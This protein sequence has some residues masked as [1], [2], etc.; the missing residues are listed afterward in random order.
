MMDFLINNWAVMIGLSALIVAII[1]W[2][3]TFLG[4]PTAGQIAKIKEWLLFAVITAEADLG[5]G[6]GQ[7]K[8]RFVYDMFVE[9]FPTVAKIIS[10]ETFSSWVDEALVKMKEMLAHNKAIA[11]IVEPLN[12]EVIE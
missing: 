11:A 10:F 1:Y 9:R 12:G 7:L 2:G 6:T 8:L 5:K 4:L 3:A